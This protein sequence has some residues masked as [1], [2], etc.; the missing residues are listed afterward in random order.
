M[1][2]QT[3]NVLITTLRFLDHNNVYLA[4][5]IKIPTW[6][7]WMLNDKWA[8]V[9][10]Q[11]R[12]MRCAAGPAVVVSV[13]YLTSMRHALTIVFSTA[14]FFSVTP[15]VVSQWILSSACRFRVGLRWR[16]DEKI[17]LLYVEGE[18]FVILCLTWQGRARVYYR[19][20]EKLVCMATKKD[21]WRCVVGKSPYVWTASDLW[22]ACLLHC[23]LKSL[24]W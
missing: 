5:R 11:K 17:N 18:G 24:A 21:H 8:P 14:A 13:C 2:I 23:A 6:R 9:D 10:L 1:T 22:T 20:L 19:K 15:L 4:V 7:L 3:L 12:D 16:S